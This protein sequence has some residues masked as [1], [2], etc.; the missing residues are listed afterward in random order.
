[1]KTRIIFLL[2]LL[3]SI[4]SQAQVSSSHLDGMNHIFQVNR[5]YV[6]TGILWDYGVNF[7]PVTNYGGIVSTNNYTRLNN[8]QIRLA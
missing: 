6:T 1:M 7:V 2:A 4:G 5:S 3:C 8:V